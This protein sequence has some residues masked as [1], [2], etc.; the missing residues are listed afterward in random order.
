[1]D[2]EIRQY[3]KADAIAIS[4]LM[5]QNFMEVN[6][7]D[8]S[9][10]EMV[11]LAKFYSP[12]KV[13]QIASD[14]HMYVANIKDNVIGCGAITSLNN[15]DDVSELVS[16]FVSPNCQGKGVGSLIMRALEQDVYFTCAK[17]VEIHSSI[18]ACEFYKK[19]GYDYIDGR[20]ILDQDRLYRLEKHK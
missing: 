7:R 6:I 12:D 18:T 13:N 9:K 1:M 5:R 16:I 15:E 17:R 2:I 11:D 14:S 20:K 8:Y 19:F 10:E 3:I 4:K